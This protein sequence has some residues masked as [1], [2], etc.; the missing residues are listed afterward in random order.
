MIVETIRLSQKAKEQLLRIKAL[1]GLKQWNELS[2]WALCISLSDPTPPS[3]VAVPGDSS[4]EMTWKTFG[5][6]AA[7]IY[8][9]LVQDRCICD[10]LGRNPRIVAEQ[11]RLH[12]HRGIGM[13][14]SDKEMQSIANLLRH[15]APKTRGVTAGGG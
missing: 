10:G 1:T 7:E 13:M 11:F 14:A 8:E 15:H 12:L 6:E 3:R 4:V 9:A 2:R 5:G